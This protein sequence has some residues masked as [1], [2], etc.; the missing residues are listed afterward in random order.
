MSDKKNIQA[1]NNASQKKRD[2]TIDRV[3][4][5]LKIMEKEGISINFLSVSKFT[6]V[7]RSWLYKEAIIKEIIKQAKT[8]SNNQL[9]QDQ[10]VK[11]KAKQR[12]VDILLKQNKHLRQ[13]IEELRKQLEVAYAEFYKNGRSGSV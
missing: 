6:G 10:A 13:Q 7:A 8:P 3:M 2:D 12:E 1:L 9:M 4:N 11:L 5:A